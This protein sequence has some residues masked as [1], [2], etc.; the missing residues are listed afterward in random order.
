MASGWKTVNSSSRFQKYRPES[1]QSR[2]IDCQAD[3]STREKFDV[4]TVRQS[5]QSRANQLV[6]DSH[7]RVPTCSQGIA[8]DSLVGFEWKRINTGLMAG[9]EWTF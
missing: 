3:S 9:S 1:S 8:K 5:K 4:V 2:E 7:P 6:V